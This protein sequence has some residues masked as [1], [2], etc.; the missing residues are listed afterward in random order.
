MRALAR[1]C[2]TFA[3]AASG[4]YVHGTA[5]SRVNGC[6]PA[7]LR[8]AGTATRGHEPLDVTRQRASIN[9]F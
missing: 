8:V 1:V 7:S 9:L 3:G 5:A 6:A 4:S 2:L